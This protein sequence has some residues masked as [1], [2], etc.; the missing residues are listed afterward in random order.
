MYVLFN[1][2]VLKMLD[3]SQ[4]VL[5]KEFLVLPVELVKSVEDYQE[6][7]TNVG[8]ESLVSLREVHYGSVVESFDFIN[9]R[10]GGDLGL[11]KNVL[12]CFV[13]SQL[14][15][16]ERLSGF[17]GRRDTVGA[18]VVLHTMRGT[19]GT[20]GAQLLST[21]AGEVEYRLT[22]DD[23]RSQLYLLADERL[24]KILR[25]LIIYSDKLLREMF[26]LLA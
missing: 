21:L 26:D 11:I 17:C 15:Q 22:N 2:A 7:L 3:R 8:L 13:I 6:Y 12:E 18:A 16:L 25:E 4:D 5:V 14:N 24:V 23:S 20:M 19:C 10:F 1:G 9:F